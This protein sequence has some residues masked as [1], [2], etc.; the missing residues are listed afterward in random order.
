M[1]P[2]EIIATIKKLNGKIAADAETI[3]KLQEENEQLKAQIAAQ[4]YV[5]QDIVEKVSKLL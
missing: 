4:K 5:L 1:D 2:K 3:K